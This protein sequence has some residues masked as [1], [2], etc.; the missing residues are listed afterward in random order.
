[1]T[2][3]Q[4]TLE[5]ND[6]PEKVESL[7]GFVFSPAQKVLLLVLVG[8]LLWLRLFLRRR[9]KDKICPHCNHRNPSHQTNC[10][11]CSAPLFGR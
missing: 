6:K 7:T 3:T 5:R 10:A 8:G 2:L 11:N 9:K 4:I 1:M